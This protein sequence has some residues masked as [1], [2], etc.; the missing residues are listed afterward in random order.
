MFTTILG[1]LGSTVFGSI[2]GV[3]GNWLNQRTI[4]KAEKVKNEQELAVARINIEMFNAKTDASIKINKAQVE[5]AIDLQ[6]SKSYATNIVVANQKSFSD[7]WIDKMFEVKGWLSYPATLMAVFVMGS[8]ALV[9]VIKGF[10]RPVLT[11]GFTAGFGYLTYISYFI[12]KQKGFEALTPA[13]AVLY[14][15]LALDTCVML[16]ATCVVWWFADRRAAKSINRMTERRLRMNDIVREIEE[17]STPEDDPELPV[18]ED[19]VTPTDEEE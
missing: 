5:G 18:L 14:F 15:T 2:I 1:F 16:T 12:L 6:D 4:L 7:K 11:I 9:D 17:P 19:E 10:M 3:F 8:L 13:Q